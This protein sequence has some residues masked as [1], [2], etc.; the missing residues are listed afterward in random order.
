LARRVDIITNLSRDWLASLAADDGTLL[1]VDLLGLDAWNQA[2]DTEASW[3]TV[4]GW[5]LLTVFS[6]EHLAVH[7]GHLATLDVRNIS[8]FLSR[9]GATL[10]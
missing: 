10:S 5:N 8:T 4:L 1:F 6:V 2:T 3:T 7:L 9:E